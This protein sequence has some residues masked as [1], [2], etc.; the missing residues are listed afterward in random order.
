MLSVMDIS[1]VNTSLESSESY[2][3]DV[4]KVNKSLNSS[5]TCIKNISN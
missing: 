1:K 4:P 5:V 2:I 3:G